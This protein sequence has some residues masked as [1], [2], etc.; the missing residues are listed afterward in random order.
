MKDTAFGFIL[1]N[2][3][4]DTIQIG[5]N[6]LKI[7]P[8]LLVDIIKLTSL[9]SVSATTQGGGHPSPHQQYRNN[10]NSQQEFHDFQSQWEQR[11][12]DRP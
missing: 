6:D 3:S 11:R 12:F 7:E 1:R 2:L 8:D 9:K 10:P 4:N 5:L